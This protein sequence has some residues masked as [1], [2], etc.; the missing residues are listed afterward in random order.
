MKTRFVIRDWAGNYPFE[1]YQ[2][3]QQEIQLG[4][5]PPIKTFDSF[6]DA[7]EFLDEFLGDKSEEY[8]EEYFIDEVDI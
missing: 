4:I 8:R 7:S 5:L 2:R 1:P 6:D 3:T